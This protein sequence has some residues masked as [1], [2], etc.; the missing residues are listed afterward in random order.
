MVQKN[1][2]K[3]MSLNNIVNHNDYGKAEIETIIEEF[4]FLH[5]SKSKF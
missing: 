2:A 4:A 3:D 1:I 5:L